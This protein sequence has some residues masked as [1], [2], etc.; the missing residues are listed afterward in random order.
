MSLNGLDNPAV[1]E[2]YQTALQEAGGWFLLKYV[3]R[4]EVA[5]FDRG[6]GGVPDVRNA[7]DAFEENSPLYGV[8]QYRRRKV[9]LSYLPDDVSRL[10]KART[11]VQFQSVLDRFSPHD[12]V[13][14]FS[15]ASGLS[16]SS[17]SST[18][19]L[20]TATD[21]MTS[22]SSGS[23]RRR[24]LMKIAEDAEESP[25]DRDV[26]S[27]YDAGSSIHQRTFSTLS[28]AT[29]T[30]SAHGAS[31]T[32]EPSGSEQ[33]AAP[34]PTAPTASR[35]PSLAPSRPGT[36]GS[37]MVHGDSTAHSTI[38]PD[39]PGSSRSFQPPAMSATNGPNAY[40]NN[41]SSSASISER[42]SSS[43]HARE[44]LPHPSSQSRMSTQSA[45]PA[46]QDLDRAGTPTMPKVKLGP[47]PSVGS[48]GRPRTAGNTPRRV[49]QRPVASLPTGMRSSSFRKA[50]P[51]PARP[52]SQGS[53]SATMSGG[54]APPVPPL[55]VPP[56]SMSIP[57]SKLSPGAKSLSALSSA[58]TSHERERLMK[59]VQMRK[60]QM[61]KRAAEGKN[62]RVQEG[63]GS[64]PQVNGSSTEDKENAREQLD[65]KDQKRIG[66]SESSKEP[67]SRVQ[68][69]VTPESA[70]GTAEPAIERPAEQ[71]IE[72]PVE[73]PVEQPVERPVERPAGL[74]SVA[75]EHMSADSSEPESDGETTDSEFA[76]DEPLITS[77]PTPRSR[78]LIDRSA[79]LEA[80][81]QRQTAQIR[82]ETET[83]VVEE[84]ALAV[85]VDNQT[86]SGPVSPSVLINVPPEKKPQNPPEKEITVPSSPPPT[87]KPLVPGE[88]EAEIIIKPAESVR[89]QDVPVPTSPSPDPQPTPVPDSS[90]VIASPAGEPEHELT[91]E[92]SNVEQPAVTR[93]DKPKPFLEPIQVP[94]PEYSD[95]DNLLSDDSFMEEL[96]SATV[97]EAKP[98][99]VGKSPL[100]PG[101]PNGNNARTAPDAWKTSRAVTNPSAVDHQSGDALAA[102]ANRSVSSPSTEV[103][104]P[105]GPVLTAKKVNLSSGISQRIK[106]LE[107][108]S[109]HKPSP[110]FGQPW[111]PPVAPPSLDKLRKRASVSLG[112]P[113]DL[114][115]GP[116][117]GSDAF[118]RA[119]SV[120]RRGSQASTRPTTRRTSSVSVT[121]RIV[122]SP[123]ESRRESVVEPSGL[124]GLNLQAS[125]LT[126]EHDTGEA[127][128]V[129]KAPEAP[130]A[131]EISE[132]PETP[133]SQDLTGNH[134]EVRSMSTSSAGS[135]PH[136][137]PAP[138]P[139]SESRLSVSPG[140]KNES[141]LGSKSP[142]DIASSPEDN[143]K[144]SRTSRLLRRMSSMT[145][146]SR[147]SPPVKE[148]NIPAENKSPEKPAAPAGNAQAVEIGELNV[149]FPGTLLWKRR[150]VRVEGD[151][152]LVLGPGVSDSTSRIAVKRY[153]LSELRTP[154]LPD[155]DEQE[156][157]NSIILD[158]LDGRTLQCAC[159]SRQGQASVLQTLIDA[160]SAHR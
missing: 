69:S 119:S 30:P 147:K 46:F 128:E 103:D 150:Y 62:S 157:P 11:T 38:T 146:S 131:P 12:A 148:Q 132:A 74:D 141:P 99:S 116:P 114:P 37:D 135:G 17:L 40:V 22:S 134:S 75:E 39:R 51:I 78:I 66:V 25:S 96:T 102:T 79:A 151:G 70:G 91:P 57:R 86:K 129:P 49:E 61:E 84:E 100:S 83:E 82:P 138:M 88:R 160:H 130:K 58:G 3:S 105:S 156:L 45:R 106:A 4:D 104:G 109:S 54:K 107:K 136:A 33:P 92:N 118:S 117:N 98:I 123:T 50:N 125:P 158:F 35:P 72:R 53:T 143:K 28:D 63:R 48:S 87:A 19:L 133:L 27:T 113:L 80:L 52:R 110:G 101:Y 153:H 142:S 56:F 2:A 139:R 81:E 115:S 144:E 93:Q 152:S 149:Q 155:E 31:S 44:D 127:P 18:C 126:V 97:E 29:V 73:Q 55:A 65:R 112:G 20:H 124:S 23:L 21:S 24:K 120:A 26:A 9:V 68:I 137:I 13:F 71:P 94:T 59:A 60:A 159:E 43:A 90:S 108:L 85:S 121:A 154:C 32:Q 64:E 34:A 7:I 42:P 76:G 5:L 6:T 122:R 77:F 16:E 145:T 95:D 89:P 47:R 111:A 14:S 8:L 41:Q 36:R 1:N 67:L 140:P 10:V 15:S